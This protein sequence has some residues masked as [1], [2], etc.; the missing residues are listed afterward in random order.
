MSFWTDERVE[1][2]KRL[3]EAGHSAGS[4]AAELGHESRNAII[5][6]LHRLGLARGEKIVGRIVAARRRQTVRTTPFRPKTVLAPSI[7]PT[8]PQPAAEPA[9]AHSCDLLGLTNR[10]CRWPVTDRPPHMFCG[11]PEADFPNVPYCRFHT[12]RACR[13]TGEPEAEAA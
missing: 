6:K 5:G 4:I 7:A 9:G 10:S 13:R 2:L 8:A 3:W 1:T 11:E 12:M